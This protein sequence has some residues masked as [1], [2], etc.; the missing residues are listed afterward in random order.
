MTM[1]NESLETIFDGEKDE[2]KEVKE[3]PIEEKENT[4]APEEPKETKTM[5]KAIIKHPFF[6]RGNLIAIGLSAF[7]AFI[8][9]FAGLCLDVSPSAMMSKKN[10]LALFAKGLFGADAL[11]E[12]GTSGLIA[13]LLVAIYIPVCIALIIFISRFAK[14]KKEK[15]YGVKWMLLYFA[16]IVVCFALSWGLGFIIQSPLSGPNLG[17]LSLYISESLLVGFF[18]YLALGVV[19]GAILLTFVN[20]FKLGKPFVSIRENPDQYEEEEPYEKK[21]VSKAFAINNEVSGEGGSLTNA[22]TS[23]TVAAASVASEET[24]LSDRDI[25]FPGLSKIDAKYNGVD[26][27]N[28][29]SDNVDLKSLSIRFRNYLAKVE[30]LYYDLP[31]I[32]FFL[33]GLGA[34]HLS[35]LEGVSGT[36]KSSLPRYFAKFINAKVVFLPVQAT[37]RDKSAI[38]GY[39]ND[40]SKRYNETDGLLN[41]YEANYDQDRLYFFVL[42]EMNI[43][44]VEYYFADFLSVLEYPVEDWK[45]RLMSFPSGYFPPVKLDDGFIRI[46][47]NCYFVGTANQDDST[48]TI[49]DKVYDRA[50]SIDFEKKNE[51][52]EVKGDYK[53]I[54]LSNHRWKE[55]I[56]DAQND[57]RASL[58]REEKDRFNSLLDFM[59]SEFGIAT[60]NR[61]LK[62]IDDLVPLYAKTGGKKEEALDMLFV[63]KV[64]SKLEGR[65]EESLSSSLDRLVALL[66]SSYGTLGFMKSKAYIK[67]LKKR[68]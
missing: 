51:P 15:W 55:L 18:V 25:A 54:T 27:D 57:A 3:E 35:I 4:P 63:R 60:G 61:I 7:Y 45:I 13:L 14:L 26:A 44:R 10:P 34:S 24:S 28:L 64:L 65:F 42:D 19:V 67:Q 38:L 12:A 47:D 29:T 43:S 48:F 17:A 16:A 37:W 46:T 22:A 1:E 23:G 31:T 11:V 59:Y 32:R 39:W 9:I 40:F 62:Q 36:G 30:N 20:F 52:F 68:L 2:E 56:L 41:L 53:A 58:T 8:V 6:S 49:A 66:D 33:A 50:I 21:D 5:D